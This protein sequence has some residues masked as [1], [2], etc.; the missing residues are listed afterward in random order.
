MKGLLGGGSGGNFST[1]EFPG[2]YGE[3]ALNL[4]EMGTGRGGTDITFSGAPNMLPNWA[5]KFQG[6]VNQNK[7]TN[8]N[9]LQKKKPSRGGMSMF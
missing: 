6:A 7:A 8:T 1:P 3:R 4:G 2:G 5:Q 9:P